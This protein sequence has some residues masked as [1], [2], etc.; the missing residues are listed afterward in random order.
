MEAF[1]NLHVCLLYWKLH[2]IGSCLL[3]GEEKSVHYFHTLTKFWTHFSIYQYL[4]SYMYM[5]N[6][7]PAVL[8]KL[9]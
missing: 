6:S 2:I 9:C 4:N 3:S 1:S 7:S 8:V 5:C